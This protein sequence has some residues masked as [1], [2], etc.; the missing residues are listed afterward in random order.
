M[1]AAISLLVLLAPGV[2]L[3]EPAQAP[4]V[5]QPGQIDLAIG[6]DGNTVIFDA[7]AGLVV[8]DTGRHASHAE[9]ILDHARKAG[10]PVAAVI[11]THWHLDHT[12]GNR[13]LL[14]AF[15][16][17]RL[18]ATSAIEGALDGFL[19]EAPARA[20]AR[21]EDAALSVEERARARRTLAALADRAALVPSSPIESG[22]PVEVGGRRFELHVAPAAATE[23]DLWL[24]A[25]D[26]GLA[27][28]GDLVVA[29]VPFF[30]T[31]CEDGWR[32][33][34]DAIDAAGWTTLI[35]GHGSRMARGD[36]ARWRGAFEAWLDCARSA[37]PAAQCAEGWMRDA[38]GF[39]SAEEAAGARMLAEGYVAEVLRAPAG[40]RMAYCAPGQP[41]QA[42]P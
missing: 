13:D 4:F 6:P 20:R 24:L 26:E 29:P 8:V 12:T 37:R 35:P 23:A 11:N 15:P 34:L 7:P 36:F 18:V 38:A 32:A 16:Q 17:A 2:C 3:A 31:G 25:P 28:V 19:A 9:A 27:V 21:A 42:T 14:A 40:E 41:S 10:K 39:Y 33:A 1:R 22:G 5:L 30:D